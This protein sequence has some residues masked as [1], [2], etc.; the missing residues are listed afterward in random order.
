[1]HQRAAGHGG[2]FANTQLCKKKKKEIL[3]TQELEETIL[4]YFTRIE[5]SNSVERL[6]EPGRESQRKKGA[7]TD[8]G[9]AKEELTAAAVALNITDDSYT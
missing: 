9:G 6:S 8:T 5:Q 4:H 2:S 7:E 3:F 1:M